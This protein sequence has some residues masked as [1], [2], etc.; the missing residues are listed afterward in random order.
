MLHEFAQARV[1]RWVGRDHHVVA[2]HI[3]PAHAVGI[4]IPGHDEDRRLAPDYLHIAVACD[5][6]EAGPTIGF[7]V[8]VDRVVLAQPGELLVRLTVRETTRI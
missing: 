4:K 1:H 8:P 2:G 3:D 6:P 5:R 7:F